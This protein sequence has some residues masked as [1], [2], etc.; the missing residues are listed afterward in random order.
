ML[1]EQVES[2]MKS[3]LISATKNH[4]INLKDV[5]IKMFLSSDME[6][7]DC[8]ILDKTT[9]IESISWTKILGMK[10]VFKGVVVDKICKSLK[11]LS[12]EEQTLL[13]DI[14]ARI[15]S[16]DGKRTPSIYLYGA[17]KPIR[18]VNLNEI[19]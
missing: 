15:Y 6:S 16:I 18:I 9:E 3:A 10:V 2:I 13:K 1:N 7:V 4:N 8:V 11:R 5:R 17:K 12:N 19:I 14:N